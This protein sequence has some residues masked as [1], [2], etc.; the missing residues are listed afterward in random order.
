M[1]HLLCL[2]AIRFNFAIKPTQTQNRNMA[3]LNVF[4][5]ES[6]HIEAQKL[7]KMIVSV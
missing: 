7:N 1:T 2:L 5:I 6:T 3:V 4:K